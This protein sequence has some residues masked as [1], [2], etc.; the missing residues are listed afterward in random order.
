MLI[1]CLMLTFSVITVPASAESAATRVDAYCTV[2][3]DGDCMVNLAV[4]LRLDAAEERLSFPLPVKASNITCNGSSVSTTKTATA[5][6]AD[7]SKFAGGMVGE[8]RVTFDYELQDIVAVIPDAEDPLA[9]PYL[10]LQL[11]L[12]S[13]FSYP[14]EQMTFV[15]T[16]PGNV[17]YQPDFISTYRQDSFGSDLEYSIPGSMGSGST[18]VSLNDHESVSMYMVVPHEM[19]PSVSTY[20]RQGNPEVVPMLIF[21]GLALLYWLLTLRTLPLIRSRNVA[22]IEGISAGELGCHL[23]LAG[24][25]LTMR[26][27]NWA[28]LGYIMIHMD[29]GRVTLHKRMDMGNERSSFEVKVF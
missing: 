23:T 24:G 5:V 26:V 27:V 15:I 29:G 8:F 4:T 28:Q 3:S 13:G 20:I 7:I 1:L 17:A 18:K 14:V 16:L 22:P 21:A 19:F 9:Q 25:D 6:L 12:L 10:Q 2:T 11:P